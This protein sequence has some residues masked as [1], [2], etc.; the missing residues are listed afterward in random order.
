MNKKQKQKAKETKEEK[1]ISVEN[2]MGYD[3]ISE[4][5][6]YTFNL[7]DQEKSQ[8]LSY[9]NNIWSTHFQ[10]QTTT[11]FEVHTFKNKKKR[12]SSRDIFIYHF[13]FYICLFVAVNLL[14]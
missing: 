9:Y 1:R 7:L 14:W 5:T 8:Y 3:D 2:L 4:F 12:K 6:L 13:L 10:E 11:T